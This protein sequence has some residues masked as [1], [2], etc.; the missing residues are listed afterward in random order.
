MLLLFDIYLNSVSKFEI[1]LKKTTKQRKTWTV[2]LSL[3][4]IISKA[5]K[6]KLQEEMR[7]RSQVAAVVALMRNNNWF[8][9]EDSLIQIKL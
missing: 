9:S 1:Q 3:N 6:T 5:L 8:Q 4:W 2:R 7:Q